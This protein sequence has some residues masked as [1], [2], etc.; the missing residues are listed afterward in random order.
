MPAKTA[1]HV[2]VHYPR[3]RGRVVLRTDVD[4]ERDVEPTKSKDGAW[5]FQL[6]AGDRP[7]V[8]FKPVLKDGS[9]PTWSQGPN[10]L[11]VADGRRATDVHPFFFSEPRCSTCD[12]RELESRR[13]ERTHRYRVFYP[14]G[15]DEATAQ[16]YPVLYMHDG[17]NLFFPEEAFAGVHWDVDATLDR[18]TSMCAVQDAL[19]VGIYPEDRM[20]DYTRPGYDAYREFVVDE[21]KPAIDAEF[22][23]LTGPE[24]TAVMGS[25]LGGVASLHF[26]WS[27]PDVFGMAACMSSTFGYQD[28]LRERIAAERKKPVRLYLDSGFPNDNYE[29]TRAMHALLLRRGYADG[30]DV[31]YL[32]FPH[33]RHDER[34]WSLRAHVPLQFLLGRAAR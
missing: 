31:L 33:D 25:S 26:A 10:R 16:R 30:A 27:S 3:D 17:Q 4:W 24:H 11:A 20:R 14:P 5:T 28:D 7:F 34:S 29:A 19:I 21:L 18:L 23:T 6:D 8:W 32:A 2:R 15:Y 9:A 12:V 22:R 13:G 1:I